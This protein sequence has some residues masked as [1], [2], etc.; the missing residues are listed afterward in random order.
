M[1]AAA[2][3]ATVIRE[4]IADLPDR[5]AKTRAVAAWL[6]FEKNEYPS[7]NR[8]RQITNAGS[9]N[10]ITR[11]L[12]DFWNEIRSKTR[13]R[14]D[15]PDLPE[16]L[17]ERMGS[18]LSEIWLL[19]MDKAG[20]Q[21]EQ[22]RAKAAE[23]IGEARQEAMQAR[24]LLAESEGRA[25]AL[26][27]TIERLN[28]QLRETAQAGS[29]AAERAQVLESQLG[30]LQDQMDERLAEK[31]GEIQALQQQIEQGRA[32]ARRQVEVLDGELRF[33]KLQIENARQEGR[34]LAAELQRFRADKTLE[35]A[36]YQATVNR[37][38]EE[39]GQSNLRAQ[40][41]TARVGE[42][43]GQ[44]RSLRSLRKAV[45]ASGRK[46]HSHSH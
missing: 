25:S 13:V 36:T 15:N 30:D 21:F 2:D 38:R 37:L 22:D 40:E 8:V 5:A 28:T 44:L 29:A 34:N 10:D 27:Q 6:F 39:L 24:T 45:A 4:R 26:Q 16:D 7:A 9:M 32:D 31:A 19:A 41:L 12:R 11:D 17:V 33:A 23:A 43:H 20:Q 42:L 14:I 46:A 1:T 18:T 35:A 3:E